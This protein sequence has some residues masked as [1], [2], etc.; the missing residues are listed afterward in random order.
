[1]STNKEEKPQEAIPEASVPEGDQARLEK[2]DDNSKGGSGS[3]P[4]EIADAISKMPPDVKR[5]FEMFAVTATSGGPRY[6]PIFDK[7]EKA[8]VDKFLDNIKAEEEHE[9]RYHSAG[10]F[11]G[12]GYVVLAALGFGWLIYFLLPQHK[13]ILIDVIKIVVVFAGGFGSGVGWKAHKSKRE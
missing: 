4:P 5:M 3:K 1:M 6:H 13:D 9:Y 2:P 10:R 11:F 7:F 8:H 12:L